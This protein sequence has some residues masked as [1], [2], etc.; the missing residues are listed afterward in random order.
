MAWLTNIIESSLSCYLQATK[1]L[2]CSSRTRFKLLQR[3]TK[4]ALA[5]YCAIAQ[6]HLFKLFP[7]G[8]IRMSVGIMEYVAEECCMPPCGT[9]PG[10]FEQNF[11][12]SS[13]VVKFMGLRG[14]YMLEVLLAAA[15]GELDDGIDLIGLDCKRFLLVMDALT[16]DDTSKILDAETLCQDE[17]GW[18]DFWKELVT[19]LS[20]GLTVGSVIDNRVAASAAKRRRCDEAPNSA[21]SIGA[22]VAHGEALS[23][24]FSVHTIPLAI[25]LEG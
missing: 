13:H 25:R 18:A 2:I 4:I 16:D 11:P 23:T 12:E 9:F 1:C 15:R 17:L 6:R 10:S 19:S 22:L 14:L 7:T 21:T 24:F 5:D 3:G 8:W 20:N